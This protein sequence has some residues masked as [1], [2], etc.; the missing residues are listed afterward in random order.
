MCIVITKKEEEKKRPKSNWT[1]VLLFCKMATQK[2]K[3]IFYFEISLSLITFFSTLNLFLF[4]F[5]SMHCRIP[6]EGDAT[7]L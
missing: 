1:S 6:M 4:Q 2:F 5:F 7:S 3:H